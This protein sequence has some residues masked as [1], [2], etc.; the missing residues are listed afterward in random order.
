MTGRKPE[1]H[2]TNKRGWLLIK[3]DGVAGVFGKKKGI[4]SSDFLE[5]NKINLKMK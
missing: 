3:G 4:S 5:M 2:G 1:F